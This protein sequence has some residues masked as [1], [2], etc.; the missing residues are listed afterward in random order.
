MLEEMLFRYVPLCLY[1]RSEG[2]RAVIISAFFFALVHNDLFVIPYAFIAGVIFM[3][4]DLVCGSVWPSVILHFLNNALSVLLISCSGNSAF[5][6]LFYG[7]LILLSVISLLFIAKKR[8]QY[9]E[10]IENALTGE[11][12]RP[13]KEILYLAVPTLILA[14]SDLVSKI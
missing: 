11:K 12:A 9:K 14:V 8:G 6:Y 3:M 4:V 1:D 7:I 5:V 13:T 2:R 10:K